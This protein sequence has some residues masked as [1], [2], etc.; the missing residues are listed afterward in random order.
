MNA[1]SETPPTDRNRYRIILAEMCVACG[2]TARQRAVWLGTFDHATDDEISEELFVSVQ[3]VQETRAAAAKKLQAHYRD[4]VTRVSAVTVL[5]CVRNKPEIE[6]EP[7]TL[8]PS[9]D[10]STRP[11][12][13]GEVASD[14]RTAED[15]PLVVALDVACRITGSERP[16]LTLRRS[17]CEPKR[18]AD[19]CHAAELAR[20]RE[21]GLR[22]ATTT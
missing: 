13:F 17:E 20:L 7:G 12:A 14:L 22:L 6:R 18:T 4:P 16:R 19:E 3:C 10:Y 9:Q 8:T 1:P 15:A 11:R 2:M 5:Q 21:L